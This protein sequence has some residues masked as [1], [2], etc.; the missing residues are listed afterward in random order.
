MI[1]KQKRRRLIK[2]KNRERYAVLFLLLWL[3]PL[4]NLCYS[5]VYRVDAARPRGLNKFENESYRTNSCLVLLNLIFKVTET[6]P[7]LKFPDVVKIRKNP[8]RQNYSKSTKNEIARKRLEL[9]PKLYN[10]L[11]F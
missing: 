3:C 5:L 7:V 8:V 2:R 6:R 10:F 9:L 1:N 11:I 4:E